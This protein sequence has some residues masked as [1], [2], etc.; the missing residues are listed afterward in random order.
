MQTK[1]AYVSRAPA[2]RKW[3]IFSVS[4]AGTRHIVFRMPGWY[5]QW[6]F[7]TIRVK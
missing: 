2:K 6:T 7:T 4:T 3:A 5:L 1:T